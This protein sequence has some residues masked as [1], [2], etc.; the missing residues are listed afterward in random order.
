[1]FGLRTV[2]SGQGGVEN[3][4]DNLVRELDELGLSV[5][6][7]IR[8]SYGSEPWVRGRATR[9]VPIWSPRGEYLEAVVHSLL[10]SLYAI[11]VRPRIVHVHAIGPSLM[12]PL[13][14]LAGLKV[15]TTHHGEDYN[16]EKWGL[17][18][19]AA[20]RLG[21]YC[22]AR[23]ANA[24][25]CVS[26]SLAKRLQSKFDS[27]F[28]Y[29]PNGVRPMQPVP[30][31]DQLARFGLLPGEYVLTVSRLVPEKRHLDLI[32][33]F[34]GL[35]RPDLRLAIVGGADYETPYS[36]SVQEHASAV[37]NVIM[38]GLLT[39][40]ALQQMFSHAG[41]FALPSTHEGLPI[42]LLEA[43]AFHRNVVASDI[44]PNL[45]I[46]LPIECYHKV[47][48]IEDLRC[49]LEAALL[50]DSYAHVGRDWSSLLADFDWTAIARKTMEFYVNVS[51]A[52]K[53][54]IQ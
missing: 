17:V 54:V 35:Q 11:I 42:A 39:G 14:R 7:V 47:G 36:R 20:L 22:Q 37:P 51:P 46:G 24:R 18:A 50:N 19:S 32:A 3:H 8:S 21:E 41:V 15:V 52:I 4:V 23:F 31:T 13:L 43:M 29:V 48:D 38:T 49:K 44:A 27:P 28:A 2:G 45:D 26:R 25:L 5:L 10:A 53:S 1:M 16:R 12:V 30:D 9:F 40:T 33:A 6:V 34:D